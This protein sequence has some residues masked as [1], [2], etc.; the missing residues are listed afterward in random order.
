MASK[1]LDVF[2]RDSLAEQVRDGGHAEGVGREPPRQA[3]SFDLTL[4]HA[5]HV[6][7]RHS[8]FREST[9]AANRGKEKSGSFLCF[10]QTGGGLVFPNEL[11]EIVPN[12]NLT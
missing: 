9:G 2:K 7:G 8:V 4:N 3:R 1:I 10:G 11:L 12:R 5:V 6:V